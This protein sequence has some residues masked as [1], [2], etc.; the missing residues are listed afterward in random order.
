MKYILLILISISFKS[1]F[2][3]S[4]ELKGVIWFEN[5]VEGVYTN[6]NG[7]ISIKKNS[8]G[9]VLIEQRNDKI[10]SISEYDKN[11]TLLSCSTGFISDLN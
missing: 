8:L 2:K 10:F 3:I 9:R 7:E 11:G 1:D 6:E 4:D 5:L